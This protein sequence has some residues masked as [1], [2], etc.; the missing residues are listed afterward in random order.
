MVRP[1]FVYLILSAFIAFFN[2]ISPPFC[3]SEIYFWED[4]GGIKHYTDDTNSIPR[5]YRNKAKKIYTSKQKEGL[6]ETPQKKI[7]TPDKAKALKKKRDTVQLRQSGN[8]LTVAAILNG[9]EPAI[10]VVDTGASITTISRKVAS[11]LNINN[12][13][14]S[15]KL[16]FSTAN[17]I[18]EAPLVKLKSIKLGKTELHDVL[19]IIHDAAPGYTGLLGLSFLN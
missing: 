3:F 4:K 13:L 9:S 8:S 18:I 5:Q 19:A 14:R 7:E 2:V 12:T 10:F 15:P 6:P 16:A 1:K 11:K 17:G